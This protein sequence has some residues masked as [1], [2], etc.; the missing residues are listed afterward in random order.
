[1]SD[2]ND[3][4][5][6]PPREVEEYT[7]RKLIRPSLLRTDLRPAAEP[8]DDARDEI[9]A[10][11]RN[12]AAGRPEPGNEMRSD[13]RGNQRTRGESARQHA[14][15]DDQPL[16]PDRGYPQA[17]DAG[18]EPGRNFEP[19][20]GRRPPAPAGGAARPRPERN[21]GFAGNGNLP[22]N[23]PKRL[24]RSENF[25]A[26]KVPP[27]EQTHAESFYY[28]KQMQAKTVVIVVMH[29]GEE[30]EG[31]IEWYDKNCI[32]MNRIDEPNVV[33]YKRNIKYL[34]KA[35]EAEGE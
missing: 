19:G 14:F 27:P 17:G 35:D 25:T 3:V 28:Q 15:P 1:M 12:P 8:G 24:P 23:H 30:L 26:K 10:G 9:R 18:L 2:A 31:I 13:L 21:D 22:R 5:A 16:T 4:T 20:N 29:D 7:Y 33:V 32:K 34:F 11:T 6:T